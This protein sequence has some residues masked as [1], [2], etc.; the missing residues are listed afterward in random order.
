M[1]DLRYGENPHQSAAFYARAGAPA[2]LLD[3][4]EQLHGKELSFNNLLDLS[5]ARELVEDFAGPACAIVKHNNPCGCALGE[6]A[7]D[8]YERAFAC[9]PESAYG[10][11]IAV[12]RPV[13]R[14]CAERMNG[15]FI[16]VLLAP[17]YDEDALE[18]LREEERAAAGAGGL[19]AAQPTST[20]ASPCSAACSCRSAT[21]SPRAASRCAR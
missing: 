15:Q 1:S 17:G 7:Q 2:H 11:V 5:S 19:A 14:G 6:S 9:D 10:G 4:V 13:D 3:G 16:E 18:V 21:R 20:T 8:A 12:N